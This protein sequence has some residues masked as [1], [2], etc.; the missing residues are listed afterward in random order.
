MKEPIPDEVQAKVK[1]ALVGQD[2]T[3]PAVR[4]VGGVPLGCLLG[5]APFVVFG[6]VLLVWGIQGGLCLWAFVSQAERTEGT[7]VRLDNRIPR[8]GTSNTECR[9]VVSYRVG[10]ETYEVH[11][12]WQQQPEVHGWPRGYRVGEVVS[13]LYDPHR[14]GEAMVD[15]FFGWVHALIPSAVGL[16]FLLLG[17]G[18]LQ[19]ERRKWRDWRETGDAEPSAAAD[20]RS[21]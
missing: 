7:V 10:D 12:Y 6:A 1:E 4:L 5:A 21:M 11:G 19:F 20:R 16:T 17:L 15:S 9:A 8:R 18:L 2:G 3:Q 14:P 13:V